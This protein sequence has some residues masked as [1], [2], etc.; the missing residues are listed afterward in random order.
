MSKAADL[1]RDVRLIS[2]KSHQRNSP[3]HPCRTLVTWPAARQMF[4]EAV[5]WETVHP[6]IR[7]P[8]QSG[9]GKPPSRK[10]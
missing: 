5:G 3:R 10:L 8:T 9:F 7:A 6:Y 1:E 4:E 2:L